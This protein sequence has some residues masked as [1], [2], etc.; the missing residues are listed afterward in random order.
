MFKIL[1]KSV[2]LL[3]FQRKLLNLD[4]KG[5]ETGYF[6]INPINNATIPIWIANYVLSDY[7]TG[8]YVSSGS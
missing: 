1:L 6:A 8:V 4:K 2:M 7:G 5:I 3:K